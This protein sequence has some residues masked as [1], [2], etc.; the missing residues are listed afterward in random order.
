MFVRSSTV[1]VILAAFVVGGATVNAQVSGPAAQPITVTV[2]EMC[3]GCV[4]KIQSHFATVT[5]VGT[6][7]CDTPT[8]TVVVT[9]AAGYSLSPRGVWEHFDSI[10]KTPVRLVEANGTVHTVKPKGNPIK[11]IPASAR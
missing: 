7:T 4:K 2:G 1:A 11:Q 5:G 6:V 9:P 8:E 10:G 3:G